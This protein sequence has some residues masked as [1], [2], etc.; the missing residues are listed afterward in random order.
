MF[1]IVILCKPALN[2]SQNYI[3]DSKR[4]TV[5]DGMTGR[6]IYDLKVDK[7]GFVWLSTW[8]GLN[9]F[10]GYE[11]K[12]YA[13]KK[14]GFQTDS[15][16]GLHVGPHDNLW[17]IRH[18]VLGEAE[19]ENP[20]QVVDIFNP[21]TEK[22]ENEI[23]ANF[24]FDVQD[25]KQINS[26]R[27]NNIWIGLNNGRIYK[28][29]KQ[30]LFKILQSKVFDSFS[31]TSESDIAIVLPDKRT[32]EFYN[33]EQ[34]KIKEH[35]LGVKILDVVA[36]N[37]NGVLVQVIEHSPNSKVR[38]QFYNVHPTRNLE[39]IKLTDGDKEIK[40]Y[41]HTKRVLVSYNINSLGQLWLF[42]QS[43][44]LV[45]DS[46]YELLHAS[47]EQEL[48][49]FTFQT[50]EQV[51]CKSSDGFLGISLQK[52]LFT[53]ILRDSNFVDTRGI[54]ED[55]DGNIYI[56]QVYTH[57]YEPKTK[58][59]EKFDVFGH[60]SLLFIDDNSFLASNYGP[61]LCRY[62]L[63]TEQ[64]KTIMYAK[65]SGIDYGALIQMYK[66][67]KTGKIYCSTEKLGLFNFNPQADELSPFGNVNTFKQ[68][69][70]NTVFFFHEN[71]EGIWM[72]TH[73]GLFLLD[74]EKGIT[75]HIYPKQSGDSPIACLSLHEDDEGYFWIGT[76]NQ[77]LYRWNRETDEVKHFSTENGLSDNMIYGIHEDDYASLWFS[78]NKGLNRINRKSFE[79]TT[80]LEE[81]GLPHEEFNLSSHYKAKDGTMY[82]G[83]LGGVTCFHPSSFY[84]KSVEEKAFVP[85]IS[86]IEILDSKN[87]NWQPYNVN[88]PD[89]FKIKLAEVNSSLRI[90]MA[91]VDKLSKERNQ[92]AYSLDKQDKWNFE[93]GN[94]LT[95][96][97]LKY[98]SSSIEIKNR[99][100]NAP[101]G[102]EILELQVERVRPT[103]KRPWILTVFVLGFLIIA[104]LV[105][106]KQK[107]KQLARLQD[108]ETSQK[109]IKQ[110][111]S[112][113]QKR[114]I[115]YTGNLISTNYKT[116]SA[117]QRW[118]MEMEAKAK[119]LIN[120]GKFSIMDIAH[121]MDLSE[122]QFRRKFKLLTNGTP[123]DFMRDLRLFKARELLIS[124][125]FKKVSEV[126][127]AV[128]FATPKHFSKLFMDKF[129]KKPSELLKE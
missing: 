5:E 8:L 40:V 75:K 1:C 13:P 55:K 104:M 87:G 114:E 111:E 94:T 126:S 127:S 129:D 26:D 42:D 63:K 6:Y 71:E 54:A 49:D 21:F 85:S 12:Y 4:F 33:K 19:A 22:I 41:P 118:L 34:E 30:G 60:R 79:I 65:D 7:A 106:F 24:P 58:S 100:K 122:R 110:L 64:H 92:F 76:F 123:L 82:F 56:N 116:E 119:A 105:F 68:F 3:S 88:T 23:L 112:D 70:K 124:K 15:Y 35:V 84:S 46:K 86:K 52:N 59:L 93:D 96:G 36:D 27:Y 103:F 69:L 90:S 102:S 80:F 20:R 18:Y 120:D 115:V 14:Y 77:G 29:N 28:Y 48:I 38:T 50:A 62:N 39:K 67:K 53:N 44:Y 91:A 16:E 9:K 10:D 66:S 37:S 125:S 72:G 78:T 31:I 83:G 11:F 43:R 95:I 99:I 61:H 74:E 113:V 47:N 32:I 25:V 57:K 81:D 17:L 45:F 109:R 97:N 121:A 73:I 108:R 101:W 117:D 98:G 107:M 2:Y 51:W 128:G 89:D